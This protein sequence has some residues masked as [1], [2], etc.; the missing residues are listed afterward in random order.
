MA[1][2]FAPCQLSGRKLTSSGHQVALISSVYSQHGPQ[3]AGSLF[4]RWAQEN[5]FRYMMQHDAIDLL[6]KHQTEKLPGTNRPVVSPIWRD[7]DKRIHP[8]N[9]RE[10]FRKA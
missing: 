1:C 8:D 7:L 5:F 6:S 9:S 4:S 10:R 3:D 2:G